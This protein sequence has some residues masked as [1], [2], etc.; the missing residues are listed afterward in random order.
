MTF[1]KK[2]GKW[3]AQFVYQQRNH[4]FGTFA[5]EEEAAH[6]Y[7]RGVSQLVRDPILNF[8]VRSGLVLC[9]SVLCCVL[10]GE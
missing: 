10:D 3:R 8:V 1:H 6:G 2:T 5:T 9:F 7:D 4:F